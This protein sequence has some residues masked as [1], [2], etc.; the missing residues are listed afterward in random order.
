MNI[1]K[2]AWNKTKRGK[3]VSMLMAGLMFVGP[4]M[5]IPGCG[6][7]DFLGLEDYQRDLLFS[8]GALALALLAAQTHVA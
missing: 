8:A 4:G 3:A 1:L 2:T 6:S 7:N 5:S